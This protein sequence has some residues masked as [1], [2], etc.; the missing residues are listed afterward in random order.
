[1]SAVRGLRLICNVY[2]TSQM[3]QPIIDLITSPVSAEEVERISGVNLSTLRTWRARKLIHARAMTIG[4]QG[5]HVADLC[6]IMLLSAYKRVGGSLLKLYSFSGAMSGHIFQNVLQFPEAWDTGD[7][8][9]V[10]VNDK[11]LHD[12]ERFGVITDVSIR[13]VMALD[14]YFNQIHPDVATVIDYGKLAE[15]IVSGLNRPIATLSIYD[16][17][18]DPSGSHFVDRATGKRVGE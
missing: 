16:L 4:P 12:P 11:Q 2:K 8:W 1:M 13:S 3:Q 14:V 9:S 6:Q 17:V 15:A 7:N 10:Y 18:N 5:Y